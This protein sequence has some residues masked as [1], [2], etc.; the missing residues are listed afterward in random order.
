ML[1][2][3]RIKDE[4]SVRLEDIENSI[5]E[6]YNLSTIGGDFAAIATDDAVFESY[7]DQ[8]LEGFD[9]AEGEA[10]AGMLDN[11]REEILMESS[12]GPIQPYASL[13]MPILVKLWARL[14]L[15]EALPTQV[16]NKPNFTVPI[17]TPYVVDADGNKHALPESINN[18][19]ETLVGLVQIKEDIAV[20][21]GKVTDYDLF[22]GLKEG[23]EV[24]KGI[25]R[26]DR[27]FKI[28][29]AKWSDSFDERTSA[30]GFVE[31]GSNVVKL[32]DNDTLVGQIKYPTNGDGEVETDTILGKVD[33]SSGELTLTSA[34]GKL[35]DVKVKGYVA[36][37]Q[38][39]S[40]TNVELGLTRKDVVIDT[41][42][43]IEA[44]VPL[45]VIQDMK[46]TYDIDGVAR[47][48]ETMSQLSSQ[49]VDL[50]II[51]FLDHEYKE[52]DAKY[53]FSFDVFP[54]SDYSAHPKD[55]LE[56]LRE[57][58]DHTT[59]SMKNDYK[60]YDVQ[61][62]I[63]GN[64]L[65][66]RLIPNVS[67]TFNGGDRNADAY[68]NGIKINYSLGAASGTANYRIIGSDLV[69][70]GE[71][72]I[73]AIPQQDNYKTFMFYPYTFNVVNGGGYLNTRNPNVPNMMMTRRYTVES[74]VPIIGRI[75][76]KNNNGSVY[77]R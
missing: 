37:E 17:L 59:Q 40:A 19:P 3:N 54:H 52:T 1:N 36:S 28:V 69:R 68:S 63:V 26:L 12:M 51:E 2:P 6:S 39:T 70:Q 8:L 18:T 46:A 43:H 49:K 76:I 41:A 25:D 16:A 56:G 48:S 44:T 13:S 72:T 31:L 60:L 32:Q 38:H 42:Q 15:T 73:I 57:V 77:A 20:E 23:K 53:H 34:S 27:K 10:L 5:N 7:K 58:I 61:F 22:T 66:V 55:W 74:F 35:T 9:A 67:W 47:L 65:D 24:R 30:A 14:A 29:E 50:D 4:F 11:T 64:P 45:E 33:V 71:L 21:G 62:V 75:T